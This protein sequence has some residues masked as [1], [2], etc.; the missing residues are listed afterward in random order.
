MWW[1]Q[2]LWIYPTM[3]GRQSTAIT[4]LVWA[5][6]HLQCR[7]DSLFLQRYALQNVCICLWKCFRWQTVQRSTYCTG[8]CQ[9]GWEGEADT[10]SYWQSQVTNS[11]EEVMQYHNTVM[12]GMMIS[13]HYKTVMKCTHQFF[14][15]QCC[16]FWLSG[17]VYSTVSILFWDIQPDW[18]IWDNLQQVLS[19][20]GRFWWVCLSWW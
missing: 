6:E 20:H 15:V 17:C 7:W 5:Q 3:G 16:M 19:V 4:C 12:N 13:F 14:Q 9:Y 1:C 2:W 8:L 10:S 11:L 18:N